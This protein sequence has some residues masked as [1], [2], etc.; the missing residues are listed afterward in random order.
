VSLERGE[1]LGYR[2]SCLP[3]HQQVHGVLS[4]RLRSCLRLLGPFALAGAF[5]AVPLRAENSPKTFECVFRAG[6]SVSYANGTYSSKRASPLTFAIGDIDLD[7]QTASLV[8]DKGKGALRI[9][10]AVNA[11]HY[12]E[13]VTEGFLNMTTVYDKDPKRGGLHPAV[14][15]R[16]LGFLGAPQIAQYQGF[17]KAK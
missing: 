5:T 11:N 10:R 6:S 13:V 12:L 8:T 3:P 14:H 4:M 9:V 2:Q 16:H 1:H 15:S 17:C 7:G